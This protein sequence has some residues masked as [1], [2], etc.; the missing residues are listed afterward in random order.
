MPLDLV[1]RI[2]N[3]KSLSK[4]TS[5]SGF[6]IYPTSFSR[7]YYL[8]D[9]RHWR[10]AL[11]ENG[12][13]RA[14]G[15]LSLARNAD[16]RLTAL[17]ETLY[18]V[19]CL[20][21]MSKVGPDDKRLAFFK[22]ERFDLMLLKSSRSHWWQPS[23]LLWY[24]HDFESVFIEPILR[25]IRMQEVEIYKDGHQS[26]NWD[27]RTSSYKAS[28]LN[29]WLSVIATCLTNKSFAQRMFCR[30]MESLLL[31]KRVWFTS[32]ENSSK[33]EK[34]T[35][36]ILFIYSS[37]NWSVQWVYRRRTSNSTCLRLP[38]ITHPQCPSRIKC[39]TSDRSNQTEKCQ[40]GNP[41]P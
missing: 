36:Y 38:K 12:S 34:E 7:H 35:H 6:A 20:S 4:N 23:N 11:S 1:Y 25:V 16:N 14:I 26:W 21:L 31:E 27:A 18:I 3:S 30:I 24:L 19:V 5:L 29:L 37:D 22:Y 33:L 9:L 15:E 8:A 17:G 10:V 32:L 40:C 28:R 13:G 39:H 41:F 2:S